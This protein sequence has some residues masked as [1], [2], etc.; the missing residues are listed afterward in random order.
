VTRIVLITRHPDDCGELQRLIEPC[1]L[2]LLPYPVL[3]L[4]DVVDSHG[5]RRVRVGLAAGRLDWIVMASPR[6]PER[7]VVQSRAIGA[8]GLLELP[9]ASIGSGTAAAVEEAGLRSE[10]VGPGTGIEL[11]AELKQR[12]TSPSSLVFACGHHR[13]EEL[14]DAL[15]AAGHE[16]LPV[17]VYR[18][19]ET[20]ADELPHVEQTPNEVVVTSPRATRLYLDS[21]GGRPL[22]CRHWALGPTT[23]DAARELGIECE[24]PPRPNLESLAE[25]LCRS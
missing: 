7:L 23:R 6:A 2:T 11:A 17:V 15:I 10:L 12:L 21:T 20:P 14:P 4:E 19:A 5:W 13:R 22:P 24:I 16:V 3:T 18:M 1:G 8:E 9:V 25:E